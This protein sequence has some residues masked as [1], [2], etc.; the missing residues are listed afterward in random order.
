MNSSHNNQLELQKNEALEPK[1]GPT[2]ENRPM[3]VQL[4]PT[5]QTDDPPNTTSKIK[6]SKNLLRSHNRNKKNLLH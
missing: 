6:L 1:Q 5:L 4:L 3:A 2:R